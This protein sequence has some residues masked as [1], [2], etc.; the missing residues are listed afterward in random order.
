MQIAETQEIGTLIALQNKMVLQSSRSSSTQKII[1]PDGNVSCI[2][3]G[4][5]VLVTLSKSTASKVEAY[6][7]D[8]L[9]GRLVDNGSLPL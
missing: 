1:I 6:D 5:H 3:S 2:Q 4:G 9:L 7:V 8:K